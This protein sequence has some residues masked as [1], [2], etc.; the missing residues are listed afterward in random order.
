MMEMIFKTRNGRMSDR[1]RAHVE[2]KFGKLTRYMDEI[3]MVQVETT[4]EHRQGEGEIH[5]IQVTIQAEHG[6]IFRADQHAPDLYAAVDMA[7][8]VLQR[9]IK[10]Y[11]DKYWRRNKL[12]R[13]T[14]AGRVPE[15]AFPASSMNIPDGDPELDD[16][17]EGPQ[18][19]RVKEFVLRPMFSDEA[20]EQMELLGHTFFVFRDAETEQVSIVYR[21]K[22][23]NYGLIIPQ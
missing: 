18:L 22:D 14:E 11:K 3:T 20:I 5:R 6:V 12:R 16:E 17:N 8:N 23:D 7:Q 19:V 2:E 1:Q 15:L 13:K 9:Q 4:T 21:R 10:R